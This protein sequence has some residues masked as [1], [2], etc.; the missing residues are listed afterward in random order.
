MALVVSKALNREWKWREMRLWNAVRIWVFM[1][2]SEAAVAGRGP[3][4]IDLT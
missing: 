2:L 4:Q 1:S 3:Y